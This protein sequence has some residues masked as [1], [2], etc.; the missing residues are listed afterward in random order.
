M[1]LVNQYLIFSSGIPVNAMWHMYYED[2]LPMGM[3]YMNIYCGFHIT[4]KK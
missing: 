4:F 2:A 3:G 1:S